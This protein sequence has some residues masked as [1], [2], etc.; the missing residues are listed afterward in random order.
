MELVTGEII[1]ALILGFILRPSKVDA[2]DSCCVV[3][4]FFPTISEGVP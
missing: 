1:S 2:F 4:E 3:F